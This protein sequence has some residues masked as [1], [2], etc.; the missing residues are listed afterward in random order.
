M[1]DRRYALFILSMFY[2]LCDLATVLPQVLNAFNTHFIT[3]QSQEAKNIA[4]VKWAFALSEFV[5]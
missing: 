2:R 1:I 3:K 4:S 5:W